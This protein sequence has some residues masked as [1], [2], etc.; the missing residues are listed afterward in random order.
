MIKE[1]KV[2]MGEEEL[3]SDDIKKYICVSPVVNEIVNRVYYR[4][5]KAK[6]Y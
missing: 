1:V 5:K 2:F 6:S 4:N 3:T